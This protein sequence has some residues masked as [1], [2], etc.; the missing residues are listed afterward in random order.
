M[1]LNVVRERPAEFLML[2]CTDIAIDDFI[3]QT[4]SNNVHFITILRSGESQS[5][6]HHT[7]SNNSN[8]SFHMIVLV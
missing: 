5:G 2:V 6:A 8:F 4:G 7:G 3:I 1:V